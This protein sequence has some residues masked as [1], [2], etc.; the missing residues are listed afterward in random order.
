MSFHSTVLICIFVCNIFMWCEISTNKNSDTCPISSLCNFNNKLVS[1]LKLNGQKLKW[2]KYQV[3]AEII[4]IRR[5]TNSYNTMSNLH[6]NLSNNYKY[7]SWTFSGTYLVSNHSQNAKPSVTNAPL[8]L[9]VYHLGLRHY[10][11]E[12]EIL[13][14][15]KTYKEKIR[16]P[17]F[18][19]V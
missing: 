12:G 10:F 15:W 8:G 3:K 5:I 6:L 18:F 11:I 9:T 14:K 4:S 7:D 13:T 16:M 17:Q 2:I 19:P 1:K